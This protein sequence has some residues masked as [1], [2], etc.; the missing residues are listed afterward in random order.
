MKRIWKK[1]MSIILG[2]VLIL[3]LVASCGVKQK[4]DLSEVNTKES[5]THTDIQEADLE[6]ANIE[7]SKAEEDNETR[8]FVDSIAREVVIPKEISKIAVTG[9]LAQIGVFAIAPEMLV[10]IATPWDEIASEFLATDYYNLPVLGQLYGGKGEMN[11]EELLIS[12]AQ[13]VIDL[14]EPKDGI[15]ED[16]DSLEKQTGIPFVHITATLATSDQAYLLLGEL[17]GKEEEGKERAKYLEEVY[18][19]TLNLVEKVEKK[20]LIYITGEEGLNVIVQGAFPAEIID[21]VMNNIAVV[22][23]PSSKG[24]GNE[25]VLEQILE[26]NP[27][28][29]IFAPASIYSSVKDDENWQAIEAIKNNT[30][31]EV[32]YGPHN[33]MGQPQSTQRYLGMM[34]LSTLFYPDQVDYS[35]KEK[36]QEYYSLFYHTELTDE[37]YE[38]LVENSIGKD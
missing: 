3:S 36:V 8:V 30:Y 32:P 6:E 31:Y 27:E 33:W 24:T 35:L 19:N 22:A 23:D 13:I 20:D 2:L 7:A 16:L 37:Q 1:T 5:V 11:L 9:P 4:T 10:G 25:V 28:R 14:G 21:L 15:V 18:S 26:W 34:W 29:I 17:L 12:D 38:V